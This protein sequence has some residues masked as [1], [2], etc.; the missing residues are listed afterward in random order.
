LQVEAS[1]RGRITRF[2]VHPKQPLREGDKKEFLQQ[3]KLQENDARY[4]LEWLENESNVQQFDGVQV[5]PAP[6]TYSITL[7]ITGSNNMTWVKFSPAPTDAPGGGESLTMPPWDAQL[8]AQSGAV[9]SLEAGFSQ[10]SETG[11]LTL[12]IEAN[13]KVEAEKTISAGSA[14][15]ETELP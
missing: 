14:K 10:A 6:K 7:R 4:S 5:T 8:S 11:K 12:Q 2:V 13:G 9:V 1:P 15:I 3:L